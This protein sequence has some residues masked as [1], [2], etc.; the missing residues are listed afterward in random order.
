M[1]QSK[2]KLFET[3]N[4]HLKSNGWL[5]EQL[6]LEAEDEAGDSCSDCSGNCKLVCL[7]EV[8]VDNIDAALRRCQEQLVALH[9]AEAFSADSKCSAYP[10]CNTITRS[11]LSIGEM[12]TCNS[13][14]GCDCS[15][16]NCF[17]L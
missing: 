10:L 6:L 7:N 17:V 1:K 13:K 9:C 12:K 14:M 3:N 11:S 16:G 8:M 2:R 15:V 5:S 4:F